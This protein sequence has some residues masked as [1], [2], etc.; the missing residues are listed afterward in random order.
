MASGK[1]V[2]QK[3]QNLVNQVFG[4]IKREKASQLNAKNAKSK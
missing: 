3:E 4:A 1:P 2:T